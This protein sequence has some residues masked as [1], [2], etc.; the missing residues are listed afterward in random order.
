MNSLKVL[1]IAAA[2][3]L[4]LGAPTA[5]FAQTKWSGPGGGGA[6]V[7]GGGI[8]A[9]GGGG[10]GGMAL[11]GGGMRAGGGGFAANP[12]GGTK[13]SGP[14]GGGSLGG[15]SNW[16]SGGGRHYQHQHHH[17]RYGGFGTGLVIGGALGSSYGYY[18]SPGYGPGYGYYDDDYYDEGVVAVAPAGGDAVEYCKQRFRSYDVRSGTYLGYDGLR[19]AC[20]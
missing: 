20:P 17:R 6:A 18:G 19:H 12:G 13:W 11:G 10:S 7:G 9:G 14:V 1:S 3:S 15:G 5:S 4:A 2:M 8:R 16:Q